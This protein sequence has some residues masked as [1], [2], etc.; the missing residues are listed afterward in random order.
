MQSKRWMVAGR[1]LLM[2]MMLAL[3][4]LPAAAV[5]VEQGTPVD[6]ELERLEGGTLSL[7]ELRGQWVVLNYWATWCAPCRKEIPDLS[8]LHERAEHIYVVGLAYEETEPEAFREFLAEFKPSYPNL[9]VDVFN[10][11]QPFGPPRALPTT[12]VLDPDGIPVKTFVGPVTGAEIE[13][14]IGEIE[15]G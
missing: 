12:I 4:A 9:L 2:V 1:R 10:P 14:F 8:A 11:P 5:E 15:G 13:A 6:F 3:T 7:A